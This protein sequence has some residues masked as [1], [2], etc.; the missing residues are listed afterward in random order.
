MRRRSGPGGF[1]VGACRQRLDGRG[2]APATIGPRPSHGVDR[3]GAWHGGH[4]KGGGV[5]EPS[6]E[7]G[8]KQNRPNYKN[9]SIKTITEV[10]RFLYLS[11]H[12]PGSPEIMKDFKQL[13]TYKPRP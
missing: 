11:S 3:G 4:D 2:G 13:S 1:A 7:D 8:L 10:V 12:N 5:P 6:R 9:V